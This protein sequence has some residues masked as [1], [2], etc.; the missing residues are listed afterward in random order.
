[1]KKTLKIIG[2]IFLVLIVI[3]NIAKLVAKPSYENSIEA[4]IKL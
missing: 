2:G 3:G 1:M 4:Q